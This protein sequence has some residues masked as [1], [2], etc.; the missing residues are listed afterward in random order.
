M[1]VLIDGGRVFGF[2]FCKFLV[3]ETKVGFLSP[4]PRVPVRE[5]QSYTDGNFGA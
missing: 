4:I 2:E 5:K 1:R 3:I